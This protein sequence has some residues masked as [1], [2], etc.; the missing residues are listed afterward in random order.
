M[1]E[2]AH[3]LT[4]LFDRQDTQGNVVEK[5]HEHAAMDINFRLAATVSAQVFGVLG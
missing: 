2:L 1:G 3:K 5:N 4:C